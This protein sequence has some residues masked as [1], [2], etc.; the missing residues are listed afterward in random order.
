MGCT[1]SIRQMES[2]MGTARTTTV[3]LSRN[4]DATAVMTHKRQR[5][6]KPSPRTSCAALIAAHSKAPV[7][8]NMFAR[9]IIPANRSTTSRFTCDSASC[10][11]ITPRKTIAI[12]PSTATTTWGMRPVAIRK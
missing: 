3:T 6:R 4:A 5:V 2:V 7:L 11:D 8:A 10:S 12:A 1:S 9:D